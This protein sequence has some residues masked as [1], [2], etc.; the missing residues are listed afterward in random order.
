[1]VGHRKSVILI[2]IAFFVGGIAILPLLGSDFLPPADRT[3]YQ[4]S[5]E[6]PAGTSIEATNRKLY[7]IERVLFN[8]DEVNGVFS[9]A[10][11]GR[12]G[13][14]SKGV[15]QVSLVKP[16]QR[17]YSQAVLMDSTRKVLTSKFSTADI[18]VE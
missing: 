13:S 9:T 1:A 2:A 6:L 12:G 17:E 4:I 10:G 11:S 14:T 3:Q 5:L 16:N 7:A 8:F 15:I 18:S